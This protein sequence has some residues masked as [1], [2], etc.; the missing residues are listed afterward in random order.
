M[1]LQLIEF[2][3]CHNSKK[4]VVVHSEDG[5]GAIFVG[6]S[7]RWRRPNYGVLKINYDGAWCGKILKGGYGG[8]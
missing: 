4:Q 8:L 1:R 5:D 7:V 6:Q 2:R 3:A